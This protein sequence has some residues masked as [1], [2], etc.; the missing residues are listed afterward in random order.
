MPHLRLPIALLCALVVPAP[1]LG[2]A[3]RQPHSQAEL[4]AEQAALVPGQRT[5]LGLHLRLD[6]GWHVYWKNPGDS[7]MATSLA[8][9]LPAG[10]GAGPIQWPH[11]MRIDTGPLTAYGY[12]GE[13]VLLA[14][15][16]APAALAAGTTVPIA[17]RADWLVCKEICIPA[18]ARLTLTLPVAAAPGAADPRW[19]QAIQ[20]ARA[21]LPVAGGDWRARAERTAAGYVLRVQPPPGAPRLEALAFFPAREG[22]I[23]HAQP[24][25]FSAGPAG[26]TLRL[27]AAA[28][29]PGASSRLAGVLVAR[30]GFGAAR[31]IEVDLAVDAASRPVES[32]LGSAAA[33]LLAFAGGLLLNLMPC[34]LP[35]LAIKLLSVVPR[36]HGQPMRLR[37]HGALFALGVLLAFWAI[38]GLLL[39]LRAQGEALGWGYQL[40]SPAIVAGLAVLLFVLGLNL[41]GVFQVGARLQSMAGALRAR[42]AHA[43]ALLSGVLASAIAAPCT[44]PFMGAALGYAL[45]RPAAEALLVFTALALGMALPYVVLCWVPQLTR[46]L[47][48]PGPWM[49]SLKQLLAFPL[50]ATVVWLAWVL[51]Q[52]SGIDALARLLA[53]LVLIAAG[54]WAIGRW[55]Q[56]GRGVRGVALIGALSSIALGL[57]FAWPRAGADALRP[58]PQAAWQPWSD[59]AMQAARDQGRAAFVDFTAAWCITCQVNKRLVLSADAVERRFDAL[60]VVRLRADW[61]RRDPA[62]TA[63]LAALDR[64]GVPVYALYPGGGGEPVLLPEVLTQSLVLDALDRVA[65]APAQA[66]A[67]IA[68]TTTKESP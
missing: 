23:A 31:A 57:A 9:T 15:I 29:P 67:A 66:S 2:E 17:A 35:V 33:L 39:V 49:D 53:G 5:T 10:F 48:R 26:Y 45:V 65:R 3:V 25:P 44:A 18:A 20:A 52:Q 6:P 19:L 56:R 42:G 37:A 4:I 54:C 30:P 38:A 8:W 58:D 27:A 21:A 60:R 47:P 59:A 13:V 36:S 22:L 1:V 51:G 41:S 50:Y 14:D 34:V 55:S 46:R 12:E 63:A 62:I 43:D 24:Q 40:Q 61:T 16:E 68:P 7:G 32:G 28:P 64:S 11:P